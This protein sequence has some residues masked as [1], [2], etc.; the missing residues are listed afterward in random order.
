MCVCVRAIVESNS[1]TGSSWDRVGALSPGVKGV[2]FHRRLMINVVAASPLSSKQDDDRRAVD[3]CYYLFALLPPD[4]YMDPFEL[5]R[6]GFTSAEYLVFGD[7][8][9]ER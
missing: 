4:I 5:E 6:S 3:C 9:V 2:G 8:D 1:T 7:T